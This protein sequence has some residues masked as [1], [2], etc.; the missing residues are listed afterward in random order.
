MHT[1]DNYL[2][3]KIKF[4]RYN[5]ILIVLQNHHIKSQFIPR[6]SENAKHLRLEAVNTEPPGF[7]YF[8]KLKL[9]RYIS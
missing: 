9:I 2:V 7:S 8:H 6:L 5:N 4:I 3:H 1:R